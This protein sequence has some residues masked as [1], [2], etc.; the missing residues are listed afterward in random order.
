MPKLSLW[1]ISNPDNAMNQ[2]HS[3]MSKEKGLAGMA[4]NVRQGYRAGG[5]A[6][7]GY[8]LEYIPTGAVRD[9]EAVTK[10]RLILD[11]NAQLIAA[12]LKGRAQDVTGTHLAESLGLK[13]ARTT[14]NG[15]EWNAL[16]YA[17]HTVGNVHNEKTD[18]GYKGGTKRRPRADWI[19]QR[20]TH[21]P[22]SRR[23]KLKL[24]FKNWIQ[25]ELRI[26]EHVQ[27]ICSPACSPT[28]MDSY[29][30]AMGNIIDSIK[31]ASKHRV[32]MAQLLIR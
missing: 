31:R 21:P 9:G 27:N 16:T 23:T 28:R 30:M 17:G 5:R 14:L 2:V 25:A 6:P 15:I 29:C 26:T 4:E 13:L 22:S 12:Y 24:S 32:S 1:W 7:F 19:I 3:F 11:E 10:S 20:D 18:D 8:Q